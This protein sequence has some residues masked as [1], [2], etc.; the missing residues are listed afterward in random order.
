MFGDTAVAVNKDDERYKKYIGMEV[1]L[2]Y[3]N[4][5]IPII[6]DEHADMEKELV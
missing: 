1:E 4:K 2:P 6:A 3:M 5:N